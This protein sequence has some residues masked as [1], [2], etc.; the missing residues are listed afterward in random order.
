[1]SES[2]EDIILANDKRGVAQLRPYLPVD[3][4]THAARFALEHP[5]NVVV[6]TGFYIL[7]SGSAET[8][9]PPGA[10]AI[11]RALQQL[12]RNVTY[13]SDSHAVPAL[14]ELVD[15]EAEVVEFGINDADTSQSGASWA[16]DQLK[17]DLLISIERCGRNRDNSYL[18]MRSVDISDQTARIDY[19]FETDVP[20]VGIGDGGN[21]IGMGNLAQVIPT[22]ANLPHLPATTWVDRLIVASV[23]N[24]GGYGLVAALSLLTGQNLLP[25]IEHEAGVVNRLVQLGLVD[26]TTGNAE[27]FVDGFTTQEHGQALERL[28][29]LVD[30]GL[31]A[32]GG[33]EG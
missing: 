14:R 22:F 31:G 26:G 5:G 7:M 24:W 13:V 15:G 17:P 2:I 3:Y 32:G 30:E 19:L 9:G 27:P 4:C 21:E 16:L 10:L 12:G 25:S 18:N 23:S 20:S 11:G 28:H 6:A 33:R 8:D 1:M 29:R